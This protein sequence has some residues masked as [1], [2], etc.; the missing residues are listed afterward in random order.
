MKKLSLIFTASLILSNFN[1]EASDKRKRDNSEKERELA[2]AEKRT[3]K[4]A[5]KVNLTNEGETKKRAVQKHLSKAEA[6][7]ADMQPTQQSSSSNSSSGLSEEQEK[8]FAAFLLVGTKAGLKAVPGVSNIVGEYL[9][10]ATYSGHHREI[11]PKDVS[12]SFKEIALKPNDTTLAAIRSAD[13]IVDIFTLSEENTTIATT[14]TPNS[15]AFS[16]D[17]SQ[18]LIA[19]DDAIEVR[20]TKNYAIEKSLSNPSSS[21]AKYLGVVTNRTTN[22]FAA[23]DSTGHVTLYDLTDK[24]ILG[25]LPVFS[26]YITP[27]VNVAL[28]PNG[29]LLAV[30]TTGE[31]DI[32]LWDVATQKPI[33]GPPPLMEA[34]S[35]ALGE[36]QFYLRHSG[37]SLTFSSDSTL[38]ATGYLDGNIIIWNITTTPPT[39]LSRRRAIGCD[40]GMD[41]SIRALSFRNDGRLLA[42]GDDHGAIQLWDI[43]SM[44]LSETIKTKFN[45]SQR[46]A[47]KQHARQEEDMSEDEYDPQVR[48][49]LFHSKDKEAL[50][51]NIQSSRL[52]SDTGA[53]VGHISIFPQTYIGDVL[54]A[55]AEAQA[56]V[57][58][59]RKQEVRNRI[60]KLLH[61][62]KPSAWDE[63]NLG[64]LKAE[65]PKLYEQ[66]Y[67]EYVRSALTEWW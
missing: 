55:F 1:L 59:Q 27:L 14:S 18:L 65:H 38:L 58:E 15:I 43:P 23:W 22:V 57:A 2:P 44:N 36:A 20:N 66:V 19:T 49:L 30:L 25:T 40:Y 54:E 62:E 32:T 9:E 28:S 4:K 64:K 17:G 46:R 6:A 67:K 35:F 42:S 45:K 8:E 13:N 12:H 34:P 10:H 51:A 41:D 61:T 7:D 31:N 21:N 52:F 63:E 11:H 39:E 47:I 16:R 50:I 26:P 29:K 24:S 3:T 53:A 33:A 48:T 37:I 5:K 60:L 56:T